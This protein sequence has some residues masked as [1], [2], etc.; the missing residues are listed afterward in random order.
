[1]ECLWI[2]LFVGLILIVLVIWLFR[3]LLK[4]ADRG[5]GTCKTCGGKVSSEAE[6]CPHCGQPEPFVASYVEV[7]ESEIAEW[8]D[9]KPGSH[10]DLLKEEVV[11]Y[12]EKGKKIEAIKFV[13]D[14]TG[15]GLAKAKK[16]VE[17]L[18]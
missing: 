12:L 2:A 3:R 9:P 16:Y 14:S 11:G 18:E 1:M 6:T 10:L 15:W 8:R 13:R 7:D 4:V 17:T 5:L